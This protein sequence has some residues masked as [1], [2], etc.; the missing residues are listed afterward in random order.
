VNKHPQSKKRGSAL[1]KGRTLGALALTGALALVSAGTMSASPGDKTDPDAP[2]TLGGTRLIMENWMQ[3]QQIISK[4]R[5]EWQQGKEI[6]VGRL[7]LAKQEVARLDEQ[8]KQTESSVTEANK[9][10]DALVAENDQLKAAN[11]QLTEAVTGMEAQVRKLF[12]ELPDP[13]QTKLQPLYQRIPEDPTNTRASAA[14][15]FQNVLGILNEVNKASGEITVTYEVRELGDGKSTEVQ[16]MYVGL[17]QAY[18]LS[19][20]GDAGIGH[21][22]PEGWKWEPSKT[23]A[24]DMATALEEIQGKHTPAFVPLPVKIQ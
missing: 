1:T 20:H 4:E 2:G 14:E 16:A 11:A 17:A 12:K 15:R 21:P 23:I 3:T 24:G 19:G 7:E 5:K 18:Y 22:T 8:I 13:I 6:L 9:K 10:R